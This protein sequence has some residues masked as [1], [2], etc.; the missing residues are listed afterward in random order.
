MRAAICGGTELPSGSHC[1]VTGQMIAQG[2]DTFGRSQPA[3]AVKMHFVVATFRLRAIVD[4]VQTHDGSPLL[5][6][7]DLIMSGCG[8]KRRDHGARTC[9]SQISPRLVLRRP[10]S[11]LP[12]RLSAYNEH[13]E[14]VGEGP[15]DLDHAFHEFVCLRTP[16][17]DEA[18]LPVW[19]SLEEL[20]S[21]TQ[22]AAR[23]WD[24]RLS[25]NCDL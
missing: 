1:G 21:R 18:S 9:V 3:A 6:D 14:S 7:G 23:R 17:G 8:L 24:V 11:G 16:E 13:W 15:S 19:G 10:A 22:A 4:V 20:V 12:L 5:C 2:R 25:P